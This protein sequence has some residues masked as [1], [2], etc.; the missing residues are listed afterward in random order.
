MNY[1]Q[2]ISDPEATLTSIC[3][4]IGLPYNQAMLNYPE[5]TTLVSLSRSHLV[6]P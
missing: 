4:F 3:N 6:S 1:E 5:T 2:L